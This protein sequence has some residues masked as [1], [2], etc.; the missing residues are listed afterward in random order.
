MFSVSFSDIS[1]KF[2]KLTFKSRFLLAKTC[3]KIPPVAKIVDKLL[4]D[5]DDI[6]VIPRTIKSDN[7]I[8]ENIEINRE[9]PASEE[10]VIPNDVLKEMVRSSRYHFI[11]DFCI[12]RVSSDCSDYPHELGCLFLGKGTKRI[13]HKFGRMVN[14]D[15]AIEHIDRCHDVGLV[16]IIGRNKID[17][18]WLNT[19]PKE[20]LL[21]ICHCCP[22]CCLWKMVPELPDEISKGFTPMIG[23]E[24]EFNQDLCRGCGKCAAD[25]IC[26]VNAIKI[27]NGKAIIDNQICRKCGKCVEICNDEALTVFI[28]PNAVMH[29]I[30]RVK[31]LVNVESE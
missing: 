11:M 21:S 6:Q 15:E 26:F 16:H 12:C 22:C 18:V 1:V 23:V 20:E 9:I 13:S 14:S 2:I 4:F 8:L 19:G 5:G 30:E 17:S 25:N 7:L 27:Q 3:K 24:I 28:E 10:S 31:R 29:S